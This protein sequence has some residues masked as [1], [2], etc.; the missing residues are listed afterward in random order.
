MKIKKIETKA[1]SFQLVFL[2]SK[3]ISDLFISYP[4]LIETLV[5]F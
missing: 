2:A 4:I 1:I 3:K 5:S